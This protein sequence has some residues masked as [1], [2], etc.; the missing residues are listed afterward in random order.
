MGL[1]RKFPHF[2]SKLSD[3]CRYG[4]YTSFLHRI[5]RGVMRRRRFVEHAA[6][7]FVWM[8]SEG[9]DASV[10]ARYLRRFMVN[11]FK[12]R[13]HAGRVHEWVRRRVRQLGRD[14]TAERPGRASA[15]PATATAPTRA[16][17]PPPATPPTPPPTAPSTPPTARVNRDAATRVVR[18]QVEAA[19]FIH[20]LPPPSPALAA[21]P[22][23]EDAEEHIADPHAATV[24]AHAHALI[25]AAPAWVTVRHPRGP[26][27]EVPIG[28]RAA[29][30][31]DAWGRQPLALLFDPDGG[32]SVV[33][34]WTALWQARIAFTSDALSPDDRFSE[35]W[36][37]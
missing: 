16:T 31:L 5:Y 35:V 36:S 9:Y 3:A 22:G 28:T 24:E 10:L 17:A 30:L 8:V 34:F 19:R 25:S 4:V 6:A 32:E 13:A 26:D 23:E 2:E 15:A 29:R 18:A 11:C 21:D 37:S 12:P 20:S 27:V 1:V 14:T 7:R 33:E